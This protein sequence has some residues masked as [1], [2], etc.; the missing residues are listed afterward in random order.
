MSICLFNWKVI[1]LFTF[2]FVN[3]YTD[4][5]FNFY[6][7]HRFI[8]LGFTI[9]AAVD[10]IEKKHCTRATLMKHNVTIQWLQV[11]DIL[12]VYLEG[13][14]VS[15]GQTLTYSGEGHLLNV[16]D[17]LVDAVDG[18]V[19]LPLPRGLVPMT[20]EDTRLLWGIFQPNWIRFLN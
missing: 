5:S 1:N 15:A 3:K 2:L 16:P 18:L 9:Q 8:M 17:A 19:T 11:L 13:D 12:F 10:I 7:L 4:Y 20:T 14:V 6:S